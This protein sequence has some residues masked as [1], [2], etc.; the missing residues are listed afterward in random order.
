MTS[1]SSFYGFCKENLLVAF[2]MTL[3]CVMLIFSFAIYL[4][5]EFRHTKEF[6]AQ[7][8]ESRGFEEVIVLKEYTIGHGVGIPSLPTENW[9]DFTAIKDGVNIENRLIC[10]RQYWDIKKSRCELPDS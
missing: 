4:I 2:F 5:F 1:S 8:L 7:E 10:Y 3:I 9:F 6:A